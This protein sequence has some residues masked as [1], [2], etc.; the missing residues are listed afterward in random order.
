MNKGTVFRSNTAFIYE[1]RKL[2]VLVGLQFF[3]KMVSLFPIAAD[4]IN[5]P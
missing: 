5:L 4:E 2:W 1:V 3:Q